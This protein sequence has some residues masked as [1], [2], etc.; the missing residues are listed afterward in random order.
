MKSGD[1]QEITNPTLIAV[2]GTL[3]EFHQD[4]LPY[5]LAAL[6]NLVAGM[7]PDLLCLDMPLAQ[8]R[9][10]DFSGLSSEYSEALLPLAAQTDI[11]VVP[12]G[13]EQVMPRAT[14]VGWRGVL[15]RW[16][17]S[18]LVRIQSDAPGP[19]AINQG[20]RHHLA[21]TLYSITRQ[22]A[23]TEVQHSY[24]QR[25]SDLTNAVLTV[26]HDNP[27]N[28]ILVVT[29]IQYCH[30]IRPRLRQHTEIEVITY[31]DL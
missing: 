17:R 19:D 15:I 6:V 16:T 20:W 28:R 21:N 26:A 10:Q 13:G 30:H 23:G 3:A 1:V 8:W 5:D 9:Q 31:K 14:A 29:N 25:I 12:I 27:G 2:L 11:V 4:P 7:N 24:H 18:L 22:L